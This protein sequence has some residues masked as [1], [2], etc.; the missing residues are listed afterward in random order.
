[1]LTNTV[2]QEILDL[3][4]LFE[5]WLGGT[6]PATPETFA[7]AG[8]ALAPGFTQIDP[9]GRWQQREPL[10]AK[11]DAAHGVYRSADHPFVI[12]I[13]NAA[14]RLTAGETIVATYEEHQRIRGAWSARISTAVFQPHAPA[15][16]GIG[17][18][19]LQETWMR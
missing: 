18:M 13:R 10:L 7:R 1:M 8:A 2:V 17:W 16:L 14:V 5:G 11:L 3:H 12:E 19:H 9:E 6:W 4:R 15:P